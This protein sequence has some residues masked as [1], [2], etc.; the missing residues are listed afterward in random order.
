LH[1]AAL[2]GAGQVLILGGKDDSRSLS[3][4]ERYDPATR[5]WIAGPD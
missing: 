5:A 4:T 3:G 2:L 1:S